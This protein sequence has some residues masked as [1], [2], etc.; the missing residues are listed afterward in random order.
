MFN[1]CS[2]AEDLAKHAC[3]KYGGKPMMRHERAKNMT[4]TLYCGKGMYSE[5]CPK[6]YACVGDHE[7]DYAVCCKGRSSSL[8][9]HVQFITSCYIM[10]L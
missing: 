1:V 5:K 9:L 8:V 3:D 10:C 2:C 6:D 7:K 4:V